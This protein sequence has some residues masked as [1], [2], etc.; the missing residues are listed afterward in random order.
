MS[1]DGIIS[2]TP[3]GLLY[4]LTALFVFAGFQLG[5]QRGAHTR[6]KAG[7]RDAP[8]SAV[9]AA[10]FGLLAF[11][12][13]FTFNMAANRFEVRKQLVVQEA[14]A[15]GTAFLRA[16]FVGEPQ[17]T[18]LRRELKRYAELRAEGISNLVRPADAARTAALQST[19]WTATVA[20]T[21]PDATNDQVRRG[22]LVQA[23]NLVFD[24]DGTRIQAGRNQVPDSI[25]F[26]LYLATFACMTTV[27]YQFGLAG[28]RRWT[29]V[30]LLV[31]VFASTIVLIA[32]LD[33]PQSGF[34]TVSQQPLLDLIDRM[35]NP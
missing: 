15:I 2:S 7:D 1:L 34:L 24:M 32:D 10:T 23:V 6:Q 26:V 5:W 28:E 33:Q 22:L 16:D 11:L 14:N 18:E 17:R 25:W 29:A 3:L 4:L 21:A 8:I 31:L 12:L 27:G 9:V 20:G 19:I 13:G 35:G 30:F